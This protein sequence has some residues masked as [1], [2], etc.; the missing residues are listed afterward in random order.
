VRR[1]LLVLVATALV[2]TVAQAAVSATARWTPAASE[3]FQIMLSAVPTT[4]QLRGAFSTMELDGVG[5]RAS[6]VAALHALGKR[7]VCYVDVGTWERWR[8]DAKKFPAVVLGKPDAGWPGERWLDVRR[9]DV[10]LPIMKARFATCVRKRFDAVDPDNVD[11]ADNPTGFPLT[12]AQQL[13]YDRA[14]ADLAHAAGLAVA[15]KSYASGASSLEPSFDLVVDEQCARYHECTS[16]GA[17]VAAG[18]PVFDIE[19][20][21]SLRF[22]RSLPSGVKGIAKHLSL[23][24]WV[25]RCA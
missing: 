19:Y 12:T 8:P 7:A 21:N 17:F 11:G 16:F 3:T 9:T 25:R 6:T 15:L 13:T 24:A 23:D 2:I 5:T 18:K 20:A 1:S 10:L 4:A 22:C 14:I